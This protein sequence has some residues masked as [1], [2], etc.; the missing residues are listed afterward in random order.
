MLKPEDANGRCSSPSFNEVTP[1]DCIKLMAEG[2]NYHHI[3]QIIRKAKPDWIQVR[4]HQKNRVR[5]C[6]NFCS[7]EDIFGLRRIRDFVE[8][9][10]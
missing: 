7:I 9:I 5:P 6:S 3:E 2:T 10:E 1:E 8:W 4:N